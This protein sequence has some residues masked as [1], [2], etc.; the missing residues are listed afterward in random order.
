MHPVKKIKVG[1][2]GLGRTGVE[3]AGQLIADPSVELLWIVRSQEAG[4]KQ[5]PFNGVPVLAYSTARFEGLLRQSKVDFI[6]DFSVA[7]ACRAYAGIAAELGI[8]IVSA[9]SSYDDAHLEL[10]RQ[11][12]RDTK[13]FHSANMTLGVNFIMMAGKVLRKLAPHAGVEVIEEHFEGKH[14]VSGTAMKMAQMLDLDPVKQINSIRVGGIL[15]RHELIFGF[16]YQTVRLSHET[17]SRAAFDQGVLFA[18]QALASKP[19]G[20]Y[21]MD[22]LL[23]ESFREALA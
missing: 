14:E 17:I 15:G 6:V 4:Q 1:L 23:L 20:F 9:I 21:T 11:A 22:Q 3:V 16:P 7:D 18:L 8:G 12:G 13:V 10:L 5:E 19:P 2:L